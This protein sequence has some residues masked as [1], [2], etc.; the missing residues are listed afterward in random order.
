MEL[1]RKR[2]YYKDGV[3]E[4]VILEEQKMKHEEEKQNC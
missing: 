2:L 4:E 3:E 1:M